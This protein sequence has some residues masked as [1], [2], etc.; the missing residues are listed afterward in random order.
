MRDC[1]GRDIDGDS[2]CGA[3]VKELRLALDRLDFAYL[4]S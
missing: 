4:R 1:D 3:E 2:G